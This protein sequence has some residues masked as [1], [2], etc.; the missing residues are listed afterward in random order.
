[1]KDDNFFKNEEYYSTGMNNTVISL[2]LSEG[3]K[4]NFN[5]QFKTLRDTSAVFFHCFT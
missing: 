4:T 3:K 1:M 5:L 2:V